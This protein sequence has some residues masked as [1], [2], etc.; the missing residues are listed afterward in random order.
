MTTAVKKVINKKF[1]NFKKDC[2]TYFAFLENY[3][4]K[5]Y[6]HTQHK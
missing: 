5:E 3:M 1:N 4:M 2:D 6:Y